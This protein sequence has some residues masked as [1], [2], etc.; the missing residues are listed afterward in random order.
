MTDLVQLPSPQSANGAVSRKRRRRNAYIVQANPSAPGLAAGLIKAYCLHKLG[1]ESEWNI[2]IINFEGASYRCLKDTLSGHYAIDGVF[3][4]R[5]MYRR[6]DEQPP[7]VIAYSSYS[8]NTGLFSYMARS[9][10]EL[11]PDALMVVGGLGVFGHEESFLRGH[12]EFQIALGGEGEQAFGSLLMELSREAPDFSRVTGLTMV[13]ENTVI[14]GLQNPLMLHLDDIPSPILLDYVEILRDGA[15]S[16]NLMLETS[17]GCPMPCSFCLMSEMPATGRYH[18]FDY[19][20]EELDWVLA[21]GYNVEFAD[22]IFHTNADRCNQIFEYL[23]CNH[24]GRSKFNFEI[25]VEILRDD[26][27]ELMGEMARRD[28]L[29][30]CQIGLQSIQAQALKL[31]R[32]PFRRERF[33]E[34]LTRFH[35]ATD[36]F[37]AIDLIF[38]LPGDNYAGYLNGIDFVFSK[39][40]FAMLLH[41]LVV[42]AGTA[43]ARTVAEHEVQFDSNTGL[44]FKSRDWSRQDMDAAAEVSYAARAIYNVRWWPFRIL[45]FEL[46]AESFSAFLLE[47]VNSMRDNGG[48][49]PDGERIL[50][51][52]IAVLAKRCDAHAEEPRRLYRA[53]LAIVEAVL[54]APPATAAISSTDPSRH[55]DSQVWTLNRGSTPIRSAYAFDRALFNPE[56][57]RIGSLGEYAE[58]R[59]CQVVVTRTHRDIAVVPGG[60]LEFLDVSPREWEMLQWAQSGRLS[61]NELQASGVVA[62]VDRAPYGESIERLAAAGVLIGRESI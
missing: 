3:M 36:N 10:R 56:R 38:G 7:D 9:F 1:L 6:L 42:I 18:S 28:M 51:T 23:L 15:Y 12:P 25:F 14:K 49:A 4:L 50:R 62:D 26:T 35:D 22:A 37:A 58:A 5:D 45:L 24:N 19:V 34:R 20:R 32:R 61:W 44:V 48:Y 30:P 31:A 16:V 57:Y 33:E 59:P 29:R 11:F 55:D 54:N 40:P 41:H 46:A 52:A 8:W 60:F 21:R 2:E 53:L 17:R 39:Q 43:Q 47:V 27:I 13:E